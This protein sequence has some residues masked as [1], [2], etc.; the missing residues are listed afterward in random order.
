MIGFF[1][2]TV[3]TTGVNWDAILANVAAITVILTAFGA[4]I[5]TTIRRSITEQV[6]AIVD[7]EVVPV[8]NQIKDELRDHDTRIARLEG[9]EEGKRMATAAAS[10]TMVDNKK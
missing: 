3:H 6:S 9:V 1:A 8:L 10:M 4:V 2:I 5:V 7:K